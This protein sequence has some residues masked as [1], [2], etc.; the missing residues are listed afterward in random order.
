MAQN[1]HFIEIKYMS[2][3]K[4]KISSLRFPSDAITVPYNYRIGNVLDQGMEILTAG[5]FKLIG[6]GSDEKKKTYLVASSSF[7]EI[8]PLKNLWKTLG[9]NPFKSLKAT[10]QKPTNQKPLKKYKRCI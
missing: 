10:A 2:G 3:S 7:E 9:E 5:G 1:L 4:V 8:K 6:Y